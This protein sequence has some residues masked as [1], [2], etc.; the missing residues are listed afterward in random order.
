MGIKIERTVVGKVKCDGCGTKR[1][2]KHEFRSDVTTGQMEAITYQHFKKQYG[3]TLNKD[4]ELLCPECVE[5]RKK[6]DLH[7]TFQ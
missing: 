1:E 3:W 7:K 5:L 4:K 2:Y 6:Q